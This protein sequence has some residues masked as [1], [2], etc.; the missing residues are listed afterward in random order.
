MILPATA[1][2]GHHLHYACAIAR[3]AI[4]KGW[5]VYVAAS[6]SSYTHAMGIELCR[7]VDSSGGKL[8]HTPTLSLR[9]SGILG[10]VEGQFRRWAFVRA[11]GVSTRSDRRFD[12]A[13]VDQADGWLLPCC[14]LGPPIDDM[15]IITVMLRTR[16]HHSALKFGAQYRVK[17]ASIQKFFISRFLRCRSVAVVATPD[18]AWAEYCA[19]RGDNALRSKVRYVPDM[20]ADIEPQ[21]RSLGQS[22]LGLDANRS[23]ILCLGKLSDRKGILELLS[24]LARTDCPESIGVLLMGAHDGGVA[25]LPGA[26]HAISLENQRR[27]VLRA[28]VYTKAEH[29]LALCAVS[30]VWVGYRDH[31]FSSGVLWEAAAAGVPVIGCSS[32]LIAYDIMSND[33]GLTV[34]ISDPVAVMRGLMQLTGDI[35]SRSRWRENALRV[36]AEHTSKGFGEG[37]VNLIERGHR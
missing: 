31:A 6:A 9:F 24:A 36:G 28:G 30:G 23:W 20:G 3:A 32:G 11:A 8:I 27:L 15:P 17:N 37:I 35:D 1:A 10:Y 5:S 29:S 25:R 33:I 34:D 7:L 26:D 12:A 18:R 19:E 16:Y 22:A 2:E 14:L 13:F 21:V 4:A